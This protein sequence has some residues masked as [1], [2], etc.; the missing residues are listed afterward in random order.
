MADEDDPGG[1]RALVAALPLTLTGRESR[2]L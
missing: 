2:D 1:H